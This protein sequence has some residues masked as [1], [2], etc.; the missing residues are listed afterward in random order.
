MHF[1]FHVGAAGLK[2]F[3][4]FTGGSHPMDIVMRR[5]GV[6]IFYRDFR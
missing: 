6:G 1:G 5:L 3:N 4:N 2:R